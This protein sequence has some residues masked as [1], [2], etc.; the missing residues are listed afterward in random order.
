MTGARRRAQRWRRAARANRRARRCIFGVSLGLRFGVLGMRRAVDSLTVEGRAQAGR[1]AGGA[2][3][4]AAPEDQDDDNNE[5]ECHRAAEAGG[6]NQRCVTYDARRDESLPI[7]RAGRCA[8]VR[9]C[10]CGW[11]RRFL[12]GCQCALVIV[13]GLCTQSHLGIFPLC[14][15]TL[16][17][18]LS[19]RRRVQEAAAP[20]RPG[21]A[22][23]TP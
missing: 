22:V 6:H 11:C 9:A 16:L 4:S 21:H 3:G 23:S 8:S 20:W 10:V 13:C 2:S 7:P 5:Q 15:S 14:T 1:G 12:S 17:S 18:G 19:T